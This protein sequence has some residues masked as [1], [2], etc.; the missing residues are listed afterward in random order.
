MTHTKGNVL[1]CAPILLGTLFP[2]TSF[3]HVTTDMYGDGTVLTSIAIYGTV[4]VDITRA[5]R[6]FGHVRLFN[7]RS[8]KF[9]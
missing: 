9:V 6:R 2:V 5:S 8:N 3:G 1:S 4:Q 7:E